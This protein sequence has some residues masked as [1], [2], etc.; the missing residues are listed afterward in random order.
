M[1]GSLEAC[2]EILRKLER[3]DVKLVIVHRGVGG[4]T[5][6]D[7]QLA[8]AS[9]ATII[10]FNVRPDRRSR[11]LAETEGVEIR[12][13]EIIYKL[14]EE[15]EAAML[16][17]LAPGLR[18]GRHRRGRGPRGLPRPA[19]GAIA[20]CFVRD[21]ASR[22]APRSASCA[23]ARSSGRARSPRCAASRTTRARCR[24]ASSAASGSPTSRTCKQG[25]IIETFEE[26]EI[27]RTA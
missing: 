3:D 27:P 17:M 16:G 21:G 23:R 5:E 19:V 20:G 15:I 24:P 22:A 4:I 9:S 8:E 6:N 1:Q 18:R 7:V 11:E 12:T 25:D 13:Y 2:T 14:I 26:R 10:G